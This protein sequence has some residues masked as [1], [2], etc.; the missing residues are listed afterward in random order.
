MGALSTSQI[1]LIVALSIIVLSRGIRL[2][3]SWDKKRKE[4]R[5]IAEGQAAAAAYWNSVKGNYDT[6]SAENAP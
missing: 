4:D 5:S 1:V 2:Y 3:I 6:D